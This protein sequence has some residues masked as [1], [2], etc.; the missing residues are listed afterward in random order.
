[1]ERVP[2]LII[3]GGVG[4]L[5]TAAALGRAGVGV[6]VLERAPVLEP[7]GAGVTLFPNAVRALRRL[8]ISGLEAM[9]ATSAPGGFWRCD[10]TLLVTEEPAQLE[11][12]YGAPLVALHRGDLQTALLEQL[13]HD[14][15]VPGADAR[16]LEQDAS[17]VVVTLAEGARVGADL[18]IGADGVH[19]V[20]R[21]T[22]LADGEPDYHGIVAYRGVVDLEAPERI[23]E[24]W[25]PGG[26]FGVVP[27]MDGRVY[28][29]A[30]R[31]EPDQEGAAADLGTTFGDWCAPVPRVLEQGGRRLRHPLV[32]RPPARAWTRGRVTLLGDAAHPMLPF[33]GQGACQAIEDAVALGAAVTL[34]GPVPAALAR[35]E[36]TRRDRVAMIVKRS[37]SA[38]RIAHLRAGWQRSLR[39][40]LIP[41]LPATVMRRQFD[42]V[43]GTP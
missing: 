38:A 32:D 7:L 31:L 29:Y 34:T 3:G 27:L 42:A 13:G 25:G 8:G 15:V 37:R 6:R 24:F 18:L 35:Y 2:V 14:I 23:G 36:S 26:V 12:R 17:G 22:I 39:D 19:S 5:A 21:A 11:R 4:G 28:W 30:T 16:H 10:G 40:R 43:I 33:L 20:T 1:M 41:A 9:P